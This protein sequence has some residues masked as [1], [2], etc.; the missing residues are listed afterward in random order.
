MVPLKPVRREL[1]NGVCFERF[2]DLAAIPLRF[3]GYPAA[4]QQL[5]SNPRASP[6]MKITVHQSPPATDNQ[7][8]PIWRSL[9]DPK[10]CAESCIER[11]VT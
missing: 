3:C 5:L 10:V 6:Q 4:I 1:W 9:H 8:L 2:G 11:E 7:S